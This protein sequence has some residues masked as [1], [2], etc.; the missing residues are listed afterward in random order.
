M[1]GQQV[2]TAAARTH[3]ARLVLA[4]GEPVDDPIS[5]K[6]ST[7]RE[8]RGLGL[9]VK[10]KIIRYRLLKEEAIKVEAALI[11]MVNHMHPDTLTNEVSGHGVAEGFSDV[12]DLAIEL[13]AKPLE[14]E[15]KLLIIKIDRRWDELIEEFSA[16]SA[17]PLE[18]IWEATRGEWTLSTDRAVGADCVLAVARGLVRAVFVPSGWESSKVEG[19]KR[20][21]DRADA[22]A[23]QSF[24]GQSVAD[25]FQKGSQNPIKYVRC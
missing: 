6:L 18:R 3:A 22:T 24:V 4:H 1:L 8:I 5:Y 21:S 23:Y 19:R 7:I 13:A 25:Y 16:G 14:T 10:H 11:D 17:V 2:S 9:Q 20:M 15:A 12:I